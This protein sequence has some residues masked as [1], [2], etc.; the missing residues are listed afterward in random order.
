MNTL[1]ASYLD[2]IKGLGESVKDVVT[3]SSSTT[4]IWVGEAGGAYNSGRDKVTNSF[5][6][7]FWFLDQLAIFAIN[8]N[9]AYCRQSLIGG[10]Y[11]LLDNMSYQP[12]PDYYSL[13][14]WS[15]LMGSR[16]LQA[17]SDSTDEL[18]IY[19]HCTKDRMGSVT[20]LFINLSNT[21]SFLIDNIIVD[22]NNLLE[23]I[24]EEYIISSSVDA[25]TSTITDILGAKEVLL[26]NNPLV[27]N[28]SKIPKL[29]PKFSI[30]NF[31]IE[32][33]TYG[34]I[35]FPSAKNTACLLEQ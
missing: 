21:T 2:Q 25:K 17:T 16:V 33:L 27:I 30:D 28:D 12:N 5:N 23:E 24:R 9:G 32:P 1:N 4:K 6:S 20:M 13:L 10:F 11:S 35:V 18:R 8:S 19:S 7:G 29:L 3:K 14:L 22:K 31:S 34:F 15:R 26:N